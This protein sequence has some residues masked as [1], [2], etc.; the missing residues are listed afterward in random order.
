MP[1]RAAPPRRS[2]ERHTWKASTSDRAEMGI[3][4]TTREPVN[5][6]VITCSVHASSVSNQR[7][8]SIDI[9]RI[10]RRRE[11]AVRPRKCA[12]TTRRTFTRFANGTR[13]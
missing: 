7:R 4:T 10:E 6:F 12:H 2:K 13:P 8:P 1:R 11:S 9:W 5:L 3:L